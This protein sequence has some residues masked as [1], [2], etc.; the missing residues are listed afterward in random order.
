MESPDGHWTRMEVICDGGRITNIVNGVVVNEGFDAKPESGKIFIQSKLAE[1]FV[2]RWE[3]WP[4]GKAPKYQ[5][6][7]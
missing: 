5:P 3:L 6:G 7:L 4:L 2:R 1:M